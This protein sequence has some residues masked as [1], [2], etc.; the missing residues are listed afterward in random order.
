MLKKFRLFALLLLLS[1]VLSGCGDVPDTPSTDDP[2]TNDPNGD[3]DK[4][5]GNMPENLFEIYRDGAPTSAEYG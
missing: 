3:K 4:E 1:I 2:P 5:D